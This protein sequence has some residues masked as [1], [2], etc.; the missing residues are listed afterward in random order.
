M[1]KIKK[2][3]IG[4]DGSH[5]YPDGVEPGSGFLNQPVRV[6]QQESDCLPLSYPT[7]TRS[8]TRGL[9]GNEPAIPFD[10]S[11]TIV[12]DSAY[13][14][15]WVYFTRRPRDGSTLTLFD[16]AGTIELLPPVAIKDIRL[17][18]LS[19]SAG[20]ETLTSEQVYEVEIVS[21]S[22]TELIPDTGETKNFPTSDVPTIQGSWHG[23]KEI[24]G[25]D[26][27][28]NNYE[29]ALS[30]SSLWDP[31]SDGTDPVYPEPTDDNI[32]IGTF[33]VSIVEIDKVTSAQTLVAD[34]EITFDMPTT[35]EG[36]PIPD[37]GISTPGALIELY[38]GLIITWPNPRNVIE[39]SDSAGTH[40]YEPAYV[41]TPGDL[42]TW[43]ATLPSPDMF[44]WRKSS[45]TGLKWDG[46]QPSVDGK[47]IGTGNVKQD[48]IIPNLRYSNADELGYIYSDPVDY[49]NIAPGMM[50]S[51][52]SFFANVYARGDLSATDVDE[53][54]IVEYSLDNTWPGVQIGTIS[55]LRSS[56]YSSTS[57]SHW[58]G[59]SAYAPFA[60]GSAFTSSHLDYVL[61]DDA[62][63]PAELYMPNDP[64]VVSPS[65]ALPDPAGKIYFRV[66]VGSN[67]SW[68]KCEIK[69]SL[70]YS[71][72]L[73]GID[74]I[75]N[76]SGAGNN[77]ILSWGSFADHGVGDKWTIN[78]ED[79]TSEV[80]EFNRG[81]IT[82]PKN[83][84]VNVSGKVNRSRDQIN[85]ALA[86]AINTSGLQIEA[87]HDG[88]KVL[89][90]QT[91]P[92]E[93]G[94]LKIFA[95]KRSS[96]LISNSKEFSVGSD[97]SVTGSF[98]G[99]DGY[100]VSY[101]TVL[102]AKVQSYVGDNPQ[103]SNMPKEEFSEP[104]F[105][106]ITTAD[107]NTN[108][109]SEGRRLYYKI[110]A[111]T[112]IITTS[113]DQSWTP[114]ADAAAIIINSG[115]FPPA[116]DPTQDE[117]RWLGSSDDGL[118]GSE[119][120]HFVRFDLSEGE[121]ETEDEFMFR[122]GGWS[123]V[124]ALAEWDEATW[125]EE[126]G[127]IHPTP[128]PSPWA[129]SRVMTP[130]TL[131]DDLG[132]GLVNVG[133]IATGSTKKGVSDSS[134]LYTER[135]ASI[136]TTPYYDTGFDLND[137]DDY[138]LEGTSAVVHEG[139]TSPLKSKTQ[140]SIDLSTASST[141]FG[142][143]QK[144]SEATTY[145]SMV[146][147][148]FSAKEWQ[149]VGSGFHKAQGTGTQAFFEEAA[150]GF[151]RGVELIQSS[152]SLA[153]L[154]I[155]DFGFPMHPKFEASEDQALSM[156]GFIDKP[157]I[158]EK[159]VLEY[160]A[161]W[162]EGDDYS[163]RSV[164]YDVSADGKIRRV[165]GSGSYNNKAAI[166]SFFILN[167]R[168][169]VGN[170]EYNSKGLPL[171]YWYP[172]NYSR[173][174]EQGDVDPK[175]NRYM[176]NGS[177]YRYNAADSLASWFKFND[178]YD[179]ETGSAGFT[180]VVQP[181]IP[182]TQEN[183]R[184]EIPWE[185]PAGAS[186]E[187]FL[188][189]I[190]F[191]GSEHLERNLNV[192]LGQS[193]ANDFH[194]DG[195]YLS[196]WPAW[197]SIDHNVDGL[198]TD[199][200]GLDNDFKWDAK[201]DIDNDVDPTNSKELVGVVELTGGMKNGDWN[202][203]FV[204]RNK[205]T[206]SPSS[207]SGL[208][209]VF[210]NDLIADTGE[211]ITLT[212]DF[213]QGI[214]TEL[215]APGDIDADG[216]GVLD[217]TIGDRVLDEP[218]DPNMEDSEALRFQISNSLAGPWV[219]VSV[220]EPDYQKQG[221]WQRNT[222]TIDQ[223]LYF[224]S[225]TGFYIRFTQNG[226]SGW[227]DAWMF[228]NVS[229]ATN[230]SFTKSIW[231]KSGA[232]KT[233]NL[234]SVVDADGDPNKFW[235]MIAKDG[236][237]RL[238]VDSGSN[239]VYTRI[240]SP[241][242]VTDGLWHNAV[243]SYDATS[244]K[245]RLW[246]D[247]VMIGFYD[248]PQT[249][250]SDGTPLWKK[251]TLIDPV[252]MSD[253]GIT[254]LDLRSSDIKIIQPDGTLGFPE[255]SDDA[256]LY[257]YTGEECVELGGIDVQLTPYEY[258]SR[259][260][261]S[262]HYAWDF[263]STD[264]V[265]LGA[266][267]DPSDPGLSYDNHFTGEMAHFAVWSKAID[268]LSAKAIYN[269]RSG[270]YKSANE[271]SISLKGNIPTS[272]NSGVETGFKIRTSVTPPN[273]A[274]SQDYDFHEK[275][276]A[277]YTVD[278][279]NLAIRAT[280]PTAY[281]PSLIGQPAF[282]VD[283]PYIPDG[284]TVLSDKDRFSVDLSGK[285]YMKLARAATYFPGHVED[286]APD[287]SFFTWIKISEIQ[288]RNPVIF[289]IN[290]EA[291]RNRLAFMVDTADSIYV[292]T[293]ASAAKPKGNRLC[294]AISSAPNAD[295]QDAAGFR[296]AIFTD[297]TGVDLN[298]RKS[299]RIL[300][301]RIGT[302][303]S[304]PDPSIKQVDDDDW[305]LVGFTHSAT[306][307]KSTFTIYF[308]GIAQHTHVQTVWRKDGPANDKILFDFMNSGDMTQ[309]DTQYHDDVWADV[310]WYEDTT[311]DGNGDT[312]RLYRRAA[313]PGVPVEDIPGLGIG[314]LYHEPML[315][316]ATD[317]LS[318]GQEYD[319]AYRRFYKTSITGERK[320]RTRRYRKPSQLFEGKITD[321]T[322]WSGKIN[323]AEAK[324]I[325]DLRFGD[326]EGSMW[327]D[328]S[329][330]TARDLVTFGQW[331]IHG[332][333]DESATNIDDVLASGL[334]REVNTPATFIDEDGEHI[335]FDKSP[336]TIIHVQ[337]KYKMEGA[338]KRP[339]AHQ[340]GL[341]YRI[342]RSAKIS[343]NKSLYATSH[344]GT[345]TGQENDIFSARAISNT[346]P[347]SKPTSIG[348]D[349]GQERRG[350]DRTEVPVMDS[351]ENNSPYI[352]MPDDKLVFGWQCAMPFDFIRATDKGTGPHMTLGPEATVD[353]ISNMKIT[354]Y[355]S[356]IQDH[357]ELHDGM[358]QNLTSD[359]IHES[360]EFETPVFDNFQLEDIGYMAG[361]YT[362]D[363]IEGEM[364]RTDDHSRSYASEGF[365]T[366]RSTLNRQKIASV[367]KHTQGSKGS[368]LRGVKLVDERER[369]FD[370]V[371]PSP[372]DY[373][374]FNGNGIVE[375]S[376]PL[377][378]G[379]RTFR[380]ICV[381]EP[382]PS[383]VKISQPEITNIMCQPDGWY[384][385]LP[386]GVIKL[387]FNQ[388]WT[389]D[390]RYGDT[391]VT[392]LD[393]STGGNG[394]STPVDVS[395]GWKISNPSQTS[396]LITV[397]NQGTPANPADD[398]YSYSHDALGTLPFRPVIAYAAGL[399]YMFS[400]SAESLNEITTGDLQDSYFT[401]FDA[402]GDPHHIN[403]Q[404]DLAQ[405]TPSGI[406]GSANILNVNLSGWADGTNGWN[407]VSATAVAIDA[408][409]PGTPA[410]DMET[411]LGAL[412][413]SDTGLPYQWD[414]VYK[415]LPVGS[416]TQSASSFA[417]KVANQINSS[418]MF[419]VL[420][421]PNGTH[422][423]SDAFTEDGCHIYV[424]TVAGGL[425]AVN[426]DDETGPTV[427]G[428]GIPGVHYAPPNIY[429]YYLRYTSYK[430][431]TVRL[432][433]GSIVSKK[434]TEQDFINDAPL[435]WNGWG[436]IT[437]YNPSGSAI[438]YNA[439]P[440]A[441]GPEDSYSYVVQNSPDDIDI[442]S[443]AAEKGL[444]SNLPGVSEFISNIRPNNTS[445]F[446]HQYPIIEEKDGFERISGYTLDGCFMQIH[447]ASDNAYN[448]W[449]KLDDGNASAP[450]A[451]SESGIL[452]AVDSVTPGSPASS[453]ASA[454]AAAL[455]AS[456][457]QA[458]NISY[459]DGGTYF[460]VE[461][462]RDGDTKDADSTIMGLPLTTG[463]FLVDESGIE[464]DNETVRWSWLS[465][466]SGFFT[467]ARSSSVSNESFSSG[468][469]GEETEEVYWHGDPIQEGTNPY[470]DNT[471]NTIDAYW[472]G[473]Y[474]FEPKYSSLF[475]GRYYKTDREW[476]VTNWDDETGEFTETNSVGSRFDSIIVTGSSVITTMQ[477]ATLDSEAGYP[478]LPFL[479][480]GGSDFASV[481]LSKQTDMRRTFFKFYFGTGDTWQKN[482]E[483]ELTN[484]YSDG[485]D[486]PSYTPKIRGWKYGLLSALPANSNAV[487]RHD[488]F[489]QF[490]DMLEQR[491]D[492]RFFKTLSRGRW[493]GKSSISPS[494]VRVKF[495]DVDGSLTTPEK[496]W[497]QNLSRFCTSSL[498][499]FDDGSARNREYPL[500][501]TQLN[502]SFG[503]IED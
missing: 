2:V 157:F 348:Y 50:N 147:Y 271:N 493:K 43:R 91:I 307:A 277:R 205:R 374:E 387:T 129:S 28:S 61:K 368:C 215:L 451:P 191:T 40:E 204:F 328:N 322:L 234:I 199:C 294:L 458:F 447:D 85:A 465:F 269:L 358:S 115:P 492:T 55:E 6:I 209:S 37:C 260:G 66:K 247:A 415:P 429:S 239:R 472:L 443:A 446:R 243:I 216:D 127:F 182:A 339:A 449:Y 33:E 295:S 256:V 153:A 193:A 95:D 444:D 107:V 267:A 318:I 148:N 111:G 411:A 86:K 336:A 408:L 30:V 455:S 296:D 45:D 65:I 172:P 404:W 485:Y 76:E 312:K 151:S 360:L 222:V 60:D 102:P 259:I 188:S 113:H 432:D 379:G 154:P 163:R 490:R 257:D 372:A 460:T 175:N 475:R 494:P 297:D 394:V 23:I 59:L 428:G 21:V 53:F 22:T 304:S 342:G 54:Y 419:E 117:Y 448:I 186:I 376:S 300:T 178:D 383:D 29:I 433:G 340:A 423:W 179:S 487:Y 436:M 467:F 401:I 349:F 424:R 42:P 232:A 197:H 134:I 310:G 92:G 252:T 220:H 402:N 194:P 167:Q 308:D 375:W 90:R 240:K 198:F 4:D 140:V 457:P 287:F 399:N 27:E 200:A 108:L 486:W 264:V 52:S 195:T 104:G 479:G 459:E 367:A 418:S 439:A 427:S 380:S 262:P 400:T 416:R 68:G 371:V 244:A 278:A 273:I 441:T 362:D 268:G 83:T 395:V 97:G 326:V 481:Y 159:F 14:T 135:M 499:F 314:S 397:N 482:P 56:Q 255:S 452:V 329:K 5:T 130:N 425:D 141:T 233:M 421:N 464:Y 338:V 476:K 160:D 356:Y 246:L 156:S 442:P 13:A 229:M 3:I 502:T 41:V 501:E 231:F 181:S 503:I 49:A 183:A 228:T 139:F 301:D 245:F 285:S 344:N 103:W 8:T 123:P 403:L 409:H 461:N 393:Y 413:P 270:Y 474:P 217:V 112:R 77:L 311:G 324:K 254:H 210:Y 498:P 347:G 355:G 238:A 1:P 331:C 281:T 214:S 89:L 79:S 46:W 317:R 396:N 392:M 282:C 290:D 72:L 171:K 176:W 345:R 438:G 412:L 63:N 185:F 12:F 219:D 164:M 58:V 137:E 118:V 279:T 34:S 36:T 67:V 323:E 38:D 351:Y 114:E 120:P 470:H 51:P 74:G 495:V 213:M 82:N 152:P 398:T 131:S 306:N 96:C 353:N 73:L 206:R 87:R 289:S 370:T 274:S 235:L 100:L 445:Q 484:I 158:L 420:E 218:P 426:I 224:D 138:Y 99:G 132:R 251:G 316:K 170:Y 88:S 330:G 32:P 25:I 406:E 430:F 122:N 35:G 116:S 466:G 180:D 303:L 136:E 226:T 389:A 165:D 280:G 48:I 221:Q 333:V 162:T 385:P 265:I 81:V 386:Q 373:H 7:I 236:T 369:Y 354:L 463:F 334:S 250:D 263:E 366:I 237:L 241:S 266:D 227:P 313:A 359:A 350:L 454:T 169:W 173:N 150:I 298:L 346:V 471:N 17:D 24:A 64:H 407:N 39:V 212:Y 462:V 93:P 166:N 437:K 288:G 456:Y 276:L 341:S 149:Q 325:H 327:N 174:I 272:F 258:M 453:V 319:T 80:F 468:R 177:N 248:K 497:S 84:E 106:V 431:N 44:R 361:S 309:A 500:D 293:G 382:K 286:K 414:D 69:I 203:A 320:Y 477:D 78:V 47:M 18:D 496:T 11:K 480:T 384:E 16:P 230:P 299:Y 352:V 155:N 109:D 388:L 62:G 357:K 292:K 98:S 31:S 363:V 142:M 335:E 405:A 391:S 196:G 422:V 201:T 364:L 305:H 478:V 168:N 225:P 9:V 161:A 71:G 381:G 291:G 26:L 144:A 211:S 145:H 15:A 187:G 207:A 124:S 489:G 223:S 10:D 126:H 94:N 192:L 488:N 125:R 435:H 143:D 75:D 119:K 491:N 242:S 70:S 20:A 343:G 469:T 483:L 275:L 434:Y 57:P 202:H 473:S 101:P 121:W 128:V 284:N 146:Y 337:G 332:A 315:F 253:A 417:Q 390:D 184:E 321:A 133:L 189:T 19:V 261:F 378:A 440:P 283:T 302:P 249:V 410:D 105:N 450:P 110:V 377:L 190:K 208:T 365:G